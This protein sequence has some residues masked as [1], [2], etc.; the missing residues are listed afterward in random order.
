M[1]NP[2]PQNRGLQLRVGA[3]ARRGHTA[4]PEL[5]VASTQALS[6]ALAH[7]AVEPAIGIADRRRPAAASPVGGALKRATDIVIAGIAIIL[8]SP[9]MLMVFVAI[10]LTSGGPAIFAH[11]RVGYN[12]RTFRCYKFRTMEHN[13]DDA[14]NGHLKNNAAA[15][16][17]WRQYCKLR[18]DPRVTPIGHIL[19]KSSLDE[20]PQL[21]NV[22]RGEMSCV[23]PRPVPADELHRYGDASADYLLARPGITGIWQI[24]GRN[25]IDYARRIALDRSYVRHWSFRSDVVILLKT[26]FVVMNFDE[27]S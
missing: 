17:E 7:E 16:S 1:R 18:H 25:K 2:L 20:L 23:G 4:V 6:A 15:T 22:L 14:L 11:S 12:G 19:R 21:F 13:A 9:V 10:L 3:T 24:S 26:L 27:T 8:L 5:R